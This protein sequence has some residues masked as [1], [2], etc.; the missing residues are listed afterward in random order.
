MPRDGGGVYTYPADTD[1]VTLEIASASKYNDRGDDL[2]TDMNTPRPIVA[3]GTGSSSASGARTNLGIS[4]VKIAS[5]TES[6]V[7]T[8]DFL[9][10]SSLYA[11]YELTYWNLVP[12]TDAAALELR[13]DNDTAGSS[14][15]SGASDYSVIRFQAIVG[16]GTVSV[17][18]SNAISEIRL[19]ATGSQSGQSNVAAD[20]ASGTIELIAPAVDAT[21]TQIQFRNGYT[22]ANGSQ[23]FSHGSAQRL[24]G[25]TIGA[26]QLFMSSGNISTMEWVL[27]ARLL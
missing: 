26:F 19:S 20:A 18:G 25:A 17:G 12:V 21:Q 8:V 11:S 24:S 2:E 3:G 15:D 23:A 9:S 1:A 4:L 10:L 5:G 7:A 27:H 22:S 13:T 14:F 6:N 16:G